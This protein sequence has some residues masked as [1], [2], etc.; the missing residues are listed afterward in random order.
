MIIQKYFMEKIFKQT[1]KI[2]WKIMFSNSVY[3]LWLKLLSL[4]NATIFLIA[5]Y[6]LLFWNI[7][8]NLE[9]SAYG[10][11]TNNPKSLIGTFIIFVLILNFFT[12]IA[13]LFEKKNVFIVSKLNVIIGVTICLVSMFILPIFSTSYY[14]VPRFEILPLVLTYKTIKKIKL[15]L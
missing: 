12:A 3:P 1:E 10:L 4:Y 15:K 11:S 9:I 7:S 5:I 13:I 2:S 8:P 14:F 6:A